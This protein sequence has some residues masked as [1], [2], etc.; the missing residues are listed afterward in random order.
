MG[1]NATHSIEMVVLERVVVEMLWLHE[2][3]LVR[4]LGRKET[5]RHVQQNAKERQSNGRL[6][7]SRVSVVVVIGTL[8]KE[9]V[10]VLRTVLHDVFPELAQEQLPAGRISRISVLVVHQHDDEILL[11]GVKNGCALL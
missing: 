6:S 10:A 5:L 2:Y 7:G 3:Q 9:D 1:Q 8:A 4:T 11:K